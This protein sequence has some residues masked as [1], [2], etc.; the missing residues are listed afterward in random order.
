MKERPILFSAPMVRAILSGL[1][2]QTRRLMKNPPTPSE[3]FPWL[4]VKSLRGPGHFVYPNALRQI[5]AEC[6]YG[7]PGD[8][9][10]VRETWDF[11][12]SGTSECMIRYFA[13]NA[14]EQRTTPSNF[15]PFI[16]G[17]EK[18]RPSI[19]MP[20]W[21]SRILLEIVS[22]RVERLQDI[23]EAD[24]LAEGVLPEPCDHS[25]RSCEEI[26]CYGD[27]AKAA[28]RGLWEQINGP[29][30]WHSNPWVWVVEFKRIEP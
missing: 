28:Y 17:N 29:S 26:G 25:R 18:K 1:K 5:L 30:S 21:A 3:H 16:Y 6:P 23:S 27:T 9:I 19:H 4:G 10:W 15:N 7:E 24:S 8:Q 13:D 11:L 2:T 12:P 20:R 14:M 22:V